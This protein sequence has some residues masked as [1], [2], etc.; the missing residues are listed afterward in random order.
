MTFEEILKRLIEN[1][2]AGYDQREGSVVWDTRASTAYE[3][4]LA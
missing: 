4:A 1:M 2:P 3:L